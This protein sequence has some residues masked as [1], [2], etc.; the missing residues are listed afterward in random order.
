M[1]T[2]LLLFTIITLLFSACQKEDPVVTLISISNQ[3]EMLIGDSK[4]MSVS[5]TPANLPAPT[6]SWSSSDPSIVA[7]DNSGNLS[8]LKVGEATITVKSTEL[9]LSASSRVKVNPIEAQSIKLNPESLDITLG[10]SIQIEA[11]IQPENTTNKTIVWQSSNREIVTI[12]DKGMVKAVGL[13]KTSIIAKT[14]TLSSSCEVN[15]NPV[16]VEKIQLNTQSLK[17]IIGSN[18]TLTATILPENATNKTI[19]WSS[20]NENIATVSIDGVVTGVGVGKTKITASSGDVKA[21]CDVIIDPIK[22][23]GISLSNTNISIEV[24]EI[25]GLEAIVLPENAT[26][27]AVAWKSQDNSIATV[28][29]NGVVTGIKAGNTIITAVTEDGNFSATCKIEVKNI[30]VKSIHLDNDNLTLLPTEKTTISAYVYPENAYNKNLIWSSSNPEVATITN[31]GNLEALQLG[32]TTITVKSEDGAAS[33]SCYVQVVE[34]TQFISLSFYAQSIVS[35]NGFITG[36]LYSTIQNNSRHAIELT[37]LKIYDGYTGRIVG[38]SNDPNLLGILNPGS[39]TNLGMKFNSVYYP[40]F[41]W[42]F[43]WN[44]KE[45]ELRRQ[46]TGTRST[47]SSISKDKLK[48][49]D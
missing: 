38:L 12:S 39:S 19:T 24:A 23:T 33:T 1:K 8:A 29:Q 18:A 27:K 3:I 13:G 47:S 4:K 5:H 25:I 46:Y 7:V 26:N 49:I 14:G 16:K 36:D 48:L 44:N 15:V 28:D 31:E 35:I 41:V 30:S 42:T 22:V 21:T 40:I 34:I 43:K 2:K 37:S 10:D 6:Y 9:N 17:I 45:Y 11:L 32:N 20:E